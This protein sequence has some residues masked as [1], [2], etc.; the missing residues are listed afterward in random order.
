[1]MIEKDDDDWS[2]I[3]SPVYEPFEMINTTKPTNEEPKDDLLKDINYNTDNH[4]THNDTTNLIKPTLSTNEIS[5]I[6]ITKSN[7]Y[8]C[9]KCI[10]PKISIATMVCKDC[11]IILC[12]D[13]KC[14]HINDLFT[15]HH[16]LID[17]NERNQWEDFEPALNQNRQIIQFIDICVNHSNQ[18]TNLYCKQCQTLIC[19]QCK[20]SQDHENHQVLDIKDNLDEMNQ[21]TTELIMIKNNIQTQIE[22]KQS[23]LKRSN[24]LIQQQL[25]IKQSKVMMEFQTIQY[26]FQSKLDQIKELSNIQELKFTTINQYLNDFS[27]QSQY[28][29]ADITNLN[30]VQNPL[31]KFKEF[32]SIQHHVMELQQSMDDFKVF[33][34]SSFYFAIN[35]EKSS[36]N[37]IVGLLNNSNYTNY[38]SKYNLKLKWVCTCQCQAFRL[39]YEN[40]YCIQ[41]CLIPNQSKLDLSWIFDCPFDNHQSDHENSFQPTIQQLKIVDHKNQLLYQ[42][43]F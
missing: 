34:S 33:G 21:K 10:R 3:D 6:D 26:E 41:T 31:Q 29:Q 30:S 24:D 42:T 23:E 18:F 15:C 2:S 20:Y 14:A 9:D 1:M 38:H 36:S 11:L 22:F 25:L 7:H 32:D 5:D 27:N 40:L 28:I 12:D 19:I 13:H 43:S 35:L 39:G 16:D 8:K 37:H 17:L 4:S